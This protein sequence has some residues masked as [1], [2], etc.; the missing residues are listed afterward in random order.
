MEYINVYRYTILLFIILSS[1]LYQNIQYYNLPS[2]QILIVSKNS[3][4]IDILGFKQ[5]Q[6]FNQYI[7]SRIL[8]RQRL[9]ILDGY[10]SYITPKFDTYYIQN[11]I[12]ILY[13]LLYIL[14]LLQLLDIGYFL[15]LKIVYRNQIYK[16]VYQR[17]FYINKVD[18]LQIYLS[19]RNIVFILQNIYASFQ[20]LGLVPIYPKYVLL[21]LIVI[22]IPS[23]L[24]ILINTKDV[25]IVGILSNTN[26]L[27]RQ[28]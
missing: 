12:F 27:Q 17:V 24:R 21:L 28:A 2:N 6:Y 3:Q 5:L 8:G 13:I 15:P 4:I 20:V 1:K 23:L 18:F 9:F 7:E 14:Y 11:K 22:R 16:L 19:I 26:Q 10:S 25:Q